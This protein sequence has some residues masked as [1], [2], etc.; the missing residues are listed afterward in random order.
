MSETI[1]QYEQY[2]RS[3]FPGQVDNWDNMQDINS[4]TAPLALAYNNLIQEKKYTEAAKYL[5]AY[6]E[7]DR[8]LFNAQKF[9][10]LMD[11]IKA[12]QQFFKDDVKTYINGLSNATIGID[13][14]LN[15]GDVGADTNSYSITKIHNLLNPE[16]ITNTTDLDN[17]KGY[18]DGCNKLYCWDESTAN[19]L[20]HLPPT[21]PA[22]TAGILHVIRRGDLFLQVIYTNGKIF[23]RTALASNSWY[24]IFDYNRL[25]TV[26]LKT[27]NWSGD[28]APYSQ[29]IFV[30]NLRSTDNPLAVKLLKDG[31]TVTEQKAYNKAFS[32]L[33]AGTNIIADGEIT[34]KVYKKPVMDFTIGL[35]GV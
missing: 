34:F 18:G 30:Q 22:S 35:K 4:L 8:I 25:L 23:Y 7:L 32:F 14:N 20:T 13:D 33:A 24:E 11:G 28:S 12:V 21:Y 15:M 27:S 9:N 1:T 3:Q 2:P 26:T 17:L 10:Q 19:L 5:S 31:A 6:P 16:V 29:T